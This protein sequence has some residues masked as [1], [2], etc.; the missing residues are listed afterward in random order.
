MI[1]QARLEDLDRLLAIENHSFDA[2]KITRRSFRY[3]LTQG[4]AETLVDED[5]GVI[6]GYTMLLFNDATSYARLYSLAVD[7][8]FRGRGVA[9]TLVQASEQCA[10][11]HECVS[12][13][14]EIRHDNRASI[15]LFS[16]SGYRQFGTI[17]DY[18]ED[19]MS[20]VRFEKPLSPHHQPDLMRVPYYR[21]TLDFTC[22][23]AAIMMGMKALN[24]DLPL[25]RKME[26]RIWREST[27]IFM[28]SGHG[29][30]G[31]YGLALSAYHRG[32]D[33]E[34]YV[35]DPGALFIDSVRDVRKKDVIRL[36]QEDFEQELQDYGISVS[37]ESLHA[38]AI[39]EKFDRGGIPVVLISSYRIYGEKEPHWVVVTGFDDR[40]IYVHDPFVDSEKG[41]S[42]I[43]C[44]NMPILKKDFERMARY[45][46]AGQKAV[47]ILKKRD[48][49]EQDQSA[50]LH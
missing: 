20:A 23:P 41:R 42:P 4:N 22:G 50:A 14:L 7:P 1:R 33:V 17:D 12:L 34:L 37:Y 18:Y 35:N 48:P 5:D 21:Q 15:D 27:T 30:C 38:G 28:A 16:S 36:V 39:Q 49:I 9:R 29:G 43:D 13:R 11:E 47:I 19:H 8:Q 3:L 44:I 45:G 2:D 31:P 25:E 6:R 26:L 40:F 10:V 24:P 46:K 32:F